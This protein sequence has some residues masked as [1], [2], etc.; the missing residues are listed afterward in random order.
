[1]FVEDQ[2]VEL[3]IYFKNKSDR[4]LE[5]YVTISTEFI[6]PAGEFKVNDILTTAILN[7]MSSDLSPYSEHEYTLPYTGKF[8]EGQWKLTVY[9]I[10]VRSDNNTLAH[11][12][13]FFQVH[14]LDDLFDNYIGIA[15][16]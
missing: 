7:P 4:I 8:W 3:D 13:T 16:G 15:G 11:S 5:F 1:M 9:A 12:T 6:E 14:S 10:D 2:N